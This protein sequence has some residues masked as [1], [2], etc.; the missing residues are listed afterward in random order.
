MSKIQSKTESVLDG[1]KGINFSLTMLANLL[2]TTFVNAS[3]TMPLN[4]SLT[5]RWAIIAGER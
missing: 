1:R 2:L 4:P 5:I 3:L